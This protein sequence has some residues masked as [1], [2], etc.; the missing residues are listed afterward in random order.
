MQELIL[1]IQPE[2]RT[3]STAQEYVRVDLM[4]EDLITL[5]Q[6]IQDVR[7]IDKVF[8]DYSK[9][10]NL[11][12]SKVNNKLFQHWYNPDIDGFD[13]QIMC[14]AIIELNYQPFKSGKIRLQEVKMKDNK[15]SIY[16][17]TFFGKTVSLNNLMGEDQLDNLIWL[18]NFNF[19][20]SDANVL[21][22][23]NAGLD[24]TVDSTTYN[25]AIIYPLLTHTQRYI[26]D[27]T[28]NFDNQ[29]NISY[30]TIGEDGTYY[31]R[32]GVLPEDLKPAILIKHII[33]AIEQQYSIT[34]KTSE[35]FDSAS[36]NNFYMWLHRDKGKLLAPSEKLVYPETFT[37]TSGACSHFTSSQPPIGMA[38][39][40]G[41]Y[42]FTGNQVAGNDDGYLFEAQ[43]NPGGSY[44]STQYTIEIINDINGEVVAVLENVTG[45][46][47]LSV[48]FGYNSTNPIALTDSF[49][50]S[51]NVKSDSTFQF[52]CVGVCTH[53][54]FNAS[55][56]TYD[57]YA[58]TFTSSSSSLAVSQNIVITN[59][60]PKI[61]VVD[62]LTG[63]FKMFNLTAY[64]ND[65]DEIV[66]QTLDNYYN[67]GDTLDITKY[68]STDQHTIG[69]TIPFTEIKYE[70]PEA[71]SILAEQF[72][73]QNNKKFG[74]LK[75]IS[76]SSKS[77]SF[78]VKAPFEHMLYERLQNLNTTGSPSYTEAQYGLF[79]NMENEP[80]I[81]QP[82]VFYGIYQTSISNSINFVES[83]RPT[84]GM[85]SAGG[86][87]QITNYWMP[88]NASALGTVSTAPTYNLNFGSEINSYTLTD[89]G[90]DNNSL[91][92]TY[93]DNYI[94]RVFNKRTRIFKFKAIL[95]LKIILQL[96][97]NDKIII[98]SRDYTI[99]KMTIKL[100]TGESSL[101]L[102]NEPT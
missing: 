36:M 35:F 69:E 51:I 97:L 9:T 99:N 63:L 46:N 20:A 94:T 73:F 6:V 93:Y 96:T 91:F 68:V 71:K 83:A 38:T 24:I 54:T 5:T 60:I 86:Q 72:F 7:Q 85:P 52:G 80:S 34:F 47:S 3:T 100:Q 59:Q 92:Q 15:P 78:E 31:N 48:G 19:T 42:S 26:Y 62:F 79:T 43:I 2:L 16:K 101:E 12:A 87:T 13:N 90:G 84:S 45:N 65:D 95:P 66:V 89:Y 74:E 70:Y 67:A 4:E 30:N 98:K 41:L 76:D 53:Y 21:S 18:N 37:C 40:N 8:T 28:G 50:L 23:L 44:T 27:S 1:Y 57:T 29:G 61:K 32:R 81:G 10:F 33:K 55:S 64:L 17:V 14:N 22:G 49:N 58:A 88:H 25:D 77:S 75:Y 39:L 11:P 82:L 56:L 102:L